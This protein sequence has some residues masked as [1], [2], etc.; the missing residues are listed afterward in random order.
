MEVVGDRWK[1]AAWEQTLDSP[2]KIRVYGE[3]VTE[4]TVPRTGFLDEDLAV[5][6]DDVGFDLADGLFSQRAD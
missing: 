1:V 4:S 6:L 2:Q 3:R 5:A